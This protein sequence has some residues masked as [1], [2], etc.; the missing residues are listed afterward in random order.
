[1][2]KNSGLIASGKYYRL[3]IMGEIPPELAVQPEAVIAQQIIGSI[4]VM[5]GAAGTLESF[6]F[7]ILAQIPPQLDGN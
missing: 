7:E 1:M 2:A 4:S 5:L 3:S 6:H